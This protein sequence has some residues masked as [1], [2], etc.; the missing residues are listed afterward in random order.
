M[1]T[2]KVALVLF[3]NGC[4]KVVPVEWIENFFP[5]NESDFKLNQKYKIWFNGKKENDTLLNGNILLL[6]LSKSDIIKKKSKRRLKYPNRRNMSFGSSD[7]SRA[8]SC[9][10]SI[11]QNKRKKKPAAEKER[12]KL[13][14]SANNK[15]NKRILK[16]Y[17]ILVKNRNRIESSS[18]DDEGGEE[19]VK[20][21]KHFYNFTYKFFLF[22]RMQ[23]MTAFFY[24]P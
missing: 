2:I 1:E 23:W 18:S 10:R 15:E 16:N 5:K 17:S 19:S 8:K 14:S 7:I 20:S 13:T 6:G 3:H 22:V 21:G 9:T 12:E 11:N 4:Q 24:R